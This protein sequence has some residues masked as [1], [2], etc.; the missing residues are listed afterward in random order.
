MKN[1]NSG[2]QGIGLLPEAQA[3]LPPSRPAVAMTPVVIVGAGIAGL[4]CAQRLA[5]QGVAAI[6]LDKGRAPGGRVATRYVE[7]LQFDHGAQYVT[8]RTPAFAAVLDGLAA[9]GAAAPWRNDAALDR[10]VGTPGMSALCKALA[11]GLDVR[12]GVEVGALRQGEG[13][14]HVQA[15][16]SLLLAGRVVVTVPAPQVAGLLGGD[17]PLVAQLLDVKMAPCLTL[18]AALRAHP[19][20]ETREAPDE[21]L[22]W[23]AQDSAKPG[24]PVANSD[25]VAWVAQAG[26]AFSTEYLEESPASIAAR[27]LPLLCER[28][29]VTTNRVIYAAAHR[30]RYARVTTPLGQA[31]LRDAS[32]TLYLGGDW[33]IG[34]RVE[35][36]WTSGTAIAEDLLAGMS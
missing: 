12:Q 26:A 32:G 23:I 8:A 29:G 14:W 19:P 10:V 15:P 27:M 31:F 3:G 7:G 9:R 18:M 13:V 5:Q 17:H 16:D 4:A 28:L 25:A 2:G 21:P 6:L 33:C 22:A 11:E 34:P 30:W 35:A 20:F 24:R 36:A 1:R